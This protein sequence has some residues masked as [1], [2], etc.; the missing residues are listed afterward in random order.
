MTAYFHCFS[1]NVQAEELR[2]FDYHYS[3]VIG[4]LDC[5]FN[6]K[7]GVHFKLAS[8]CA[9]TECNDTYLG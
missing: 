7:D 3:L 1:S 6:S 5:H 8:D 9:A 4:D 2:E